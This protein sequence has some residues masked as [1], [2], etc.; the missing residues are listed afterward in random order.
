LRSLLSYLSFIYKKITTFKK[1]NPV[2]YEYPFSNK[3]IPLFARLKISNDFQKCT[4]CRQCE[5][6]CPTNAISIYGD[7]ISQNVNKN[8][9]KDGNEILMDI[10]KFE[11][12]YSKC[13]FCGIC[14]EDCPAKSLTNLKSFVNCEDEIRHLKVDLKSQDRPKIK[15]IN[16]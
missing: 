6:S 5:K 4:G 16:R 1:H 8:L 9:T 10:H 12:D 11:I 13:I 14:I 15:G 2:T 3:H 7:E